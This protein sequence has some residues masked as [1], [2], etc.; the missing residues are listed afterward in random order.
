M[1]D[2]SL[3]NCISFFLEPEFHQVDFHFPSTD[4]KHVTC[5]FP[6]S[7][8][9]FVIEC[10][11]RIPKLAVIYLITDCSVKEF[12]AI[13]VWQRLHKIAIKYDI[14]MLISQ[15]GLRH[16]TFKYD[17]AGKSWMTFYK[18]QVVAALGANVFKFSMVVDYMNANFSKPKSIRKSKSYL[19]ERKTILTQPVPHY[20]SKFKALSFG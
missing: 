1:P 11:N 13:S 20:R 2:F 6:K 4:P 15:F 8:E 17:H 18:K 16:G 7:F 3:L 12:K 9:Q 10:I 19:T 14:R 5:L